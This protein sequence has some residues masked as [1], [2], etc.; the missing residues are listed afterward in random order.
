LIV[1]Y[2]QERKKDMSQQDSSTLPPGKR[3]QGK[4][5]TSEQ[6]G[7]GKAS[8]TR[9]TRK[10]SSR[11]QAGDLSLDF[12][13]TMY[14]DDFLLNEASLIRWSQEVGL[15]TE[16]GAQALLEETEASP[17]DS[18]AL[19][20][21]VLALRQASYRVLL[22]FIDHTP[23]TASDVDV[24]QS[25]FVQARSHERLVP[26]E[27]HLAWQW[28]EAESGLAGLYWVLSRSVESVLTSPTMERVKQCP[29]S[30]GGCG[31]FFVDRS[32]NSSRQWCSDQACGSLVRMRHLY[33]RKRANKER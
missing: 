28:E 16:E 9:S 18:R 21:Q 33:A 3:W 24:L 22:A 20:T 26:A 23:P 32:K 13:N 10:P 2:I 11:L 8:T 30:L 1:K 4:V 17:E 27:H 29:P 7:G 14:P 5:K 31:W 25:V 6:T 12:V 19:F 15:V